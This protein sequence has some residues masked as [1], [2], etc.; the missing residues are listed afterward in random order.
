MD[1]ILFKSMKSIKHSN[2]IFNV[3]RTISNSSS[4]EN[5]KTIIKEMMRLGKVK[6]KMRFESN[7]DKLIQLKVDGKVQNK[8][9]LIQLFYFFKF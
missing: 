8:Y 7:H 5:T 9:E 2:N 1:N 4:F 6:T 3:L